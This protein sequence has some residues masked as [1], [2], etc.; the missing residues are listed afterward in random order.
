M[1]GAARAAVAVSI[2]A[3][4]L[5]SSTNVA[6]Q[7]AFR[8]ANLKP[9][10]SSLEGG[11]WGE[12]DKAEMALKTSGELNRDQK[13]TTYVKG[14]LCRI[15]SQYCGEIRVYVVDRPFL[16]AGV[17]PNGCVEI[18]S[19]L[20]LRARTEDELAFVLGHE[21]THFARNHSLQKWE[22]NKATKNAVLA[23]QI[24]VT[25]GAAAAMYSA[26]STGSPY[27]PSTIDSISRSAQSLNNLIYLAGLASTFAYSREAETEADELGFRRYHAAHY[28]AA[29]ASSI[30]RYVED[31]NA[32]SDFEAV[33]RTEARASIFMTHPI[34]AQRIA[35]LTAL[36][37]ADAG[38]QPAR[39]DLLRYRAAIRH[40]MAAWLRD[41]L[42]RKDFGQ[43][44]FLLDRLAAPGEDLGVINFYRGEAYR[45]RRREGDIQKS[46]LAYQTASTYPD[47]PV[48]AWRELGEA[49]RKGGD[50]PAA[51]AAFEAYLE[52]APGAKDRWLVEASLKS[53]QVGGVQ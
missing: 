28:Q 37:G 4:L 36:A 51:K 34:T 41:D 44:L 46:A 2:S 7:P 11:I 40:Q 15:A 17:L 31:E 27:A 18:N 48:E 6:A 24:G 8:P 50:K 53:I 20:L 5:L 38:A 33:R 1:N 52:K 49:L 25:L 9:D 23:L 29:A 21:V 26:A 43:T 19:G 22:Q 47:A 16:N 32:A 39:E 35:A 12:S 30:W 42:R 14:V 3:A 13:L 10:L 45:L